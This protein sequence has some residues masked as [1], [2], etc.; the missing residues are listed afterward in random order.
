MID[1]SEYRLMP[2]LNER[3]EVTPSDCTSIGGTCGGQLFVLTPRWP[4]EPLK[5]AEWARANHLM[6]L[7]RFYM[8]PTCGVVQQW[9]YEPA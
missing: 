4:G 3:G 2:C 5:A 8:C 7:P 1:V 9:T 6:S